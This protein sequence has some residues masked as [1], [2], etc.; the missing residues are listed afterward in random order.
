[1]PKLKYTVAIPV[2]DYADA[3]KKVQKFVKRGFIDD[4]EWNKSMIVRDTCNHVIVTFK[5]NLVGI[6]SHSG[7]DT[8]VI[9]G[10]VRDV[11]KY[12]VKD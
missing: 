9:L 2:K 1:M 3:L 11:E 7:C 6:Y 5:D 4:V 12:Y 10:R 8:K